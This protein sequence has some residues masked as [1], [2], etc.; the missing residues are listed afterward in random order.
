MAVNKVQYAGNTLIDLTSDS[1]T[2][3]Q[4]LSGVTAHAAT[5][6]VITGTLEASAVITDYIIDE[7]DQTIRIIT[8]DK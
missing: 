8:L 7:A 6:E 5:G 3:D 1:V 2:A 4:L